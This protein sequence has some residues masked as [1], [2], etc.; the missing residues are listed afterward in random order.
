MIY[1]GFLLSL[2]NGKDY[3][4]FNEVIGAMDLN[5][6]KFVSQYV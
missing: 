3:N 6:Q 4:T 5:I 2:A 1:K